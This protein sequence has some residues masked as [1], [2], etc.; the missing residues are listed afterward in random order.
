M[1]GGKEERQFC[2]VT[3]AW[4]SPP[5]VRARHPVFLRCPAAAQSSQ[6][7]NSQTLTSP[8]SRGNRT[9]M[10][11]ALCYALPL[12]PV[13]WKHGMNFRC[14]PSSCISIS[15]PDSPQQHCRKI[16]QPA[17]AACSKRSSSNPSAEQ[18]CC[19]HAAPRNSQA[20]SQHTDT[21]GRYTQ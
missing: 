16:P 6:Q 21:Q 15:S 20:P 8:K 5:G 19:Y 17:A 2:C 4:N 3:K 1:L 7:N 11:S 13:T 12:G 10:H 9:K 18:Y 14:C